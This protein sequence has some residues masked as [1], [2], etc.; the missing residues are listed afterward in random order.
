MCLPIAEVEHSGISYGELNEAKVERMSLS[1]TVGGHYP[2]A[3][4]RFWDEVFFTEAYTNDLFLKGLGFPS[5]ERM[6]FTAEDNGEI[7]RTMKVS[8]KL[9]LPNALKRLVK[10][11]LL[12]I[13]TGVFEPQSKVFTSVIT[14]PASP[15]LLTIKAKMTFTDAPAGGCLR[16]V[17]FDVTS[18]TFG[19]ATL[20]EKTTRV[21]LNQQYKTAE[22]YT[23][24]WLESKG[25]AE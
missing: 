10:G 1:F 13:E 23:R 3:A 19:I 12:Y 16:H 15:K 6:S 8:P 24:Q 7:R 18:S 14:V 5:V 4:D 11:G 2:I 20:V 21:V 25:L 22:V 9:T 17:E